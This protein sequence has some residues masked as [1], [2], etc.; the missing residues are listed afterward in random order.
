MGEGTGEMSED[1]VIYTAKKFITME[2]ALPEATAVAVKDGRIVGVGTL[3]SLKPWTDSH[4]YRVDTM[5]EDK[6]VMPGLIDPHV[7]P[8]LP[9]VLTPGVF[10]APDDWTLPMGFFPGATNHEDFVELLKGY[11]AQHEDWSV[12]FIAWGFHELW[13]GDVYREKLDALFGDRPVILWQRSF[14]ELIFNSAALDFVGLSEADVEGNDEIVW[15][16]GHFWEMGAQM[17]MVKLGPVLF[18]PGRYGAGMKTF[19]DMCHQSGVT[20]VAD[21]GTGIFGDPVGETALIRDT[22]ESNE[23]PTRI[24]LTPIIT[25]FRGRGKTPQEALDEIDEWREGNTRRVMFDRRFKIMMDGAIF[26][27]QSQFDFPGYIDGHEGAW[28]APLDV[29]REWAEAF[30]KEGYQ[31][32]A[33]VNGDLST[34]E[35]LNLL[36]H[37]QKVHPRVDHRFS[38]EHFAYATEDQNRQIKALDAV[39]SANPYYHYI[40]SDIYS[41]QWLGVDRGSQMV[42][43]GS[44]ERLGVPFTLHSDCPMAPLAPLTLAWCAANRVTI[45]G[46]VH[47]EE[48]I[49]LDAA[50]RAVTID[51]AWVL[52]YED[53]IGSIRAGKNA[54]FT[55]LE[56]DPY[57]VGAEGLKDIGIWGTVFEGELH[58]I[59]KGA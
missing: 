44:L 43:L 30:W 29:T 10:L 56:D 59:D 46:N 48:L 5:L 24:I 47:P 40:L 8:S 17:M 2:P 16:K 38:L 57:E 45:N 42:R 31:I 1:L 18:E 3:E 28:L 26:G 12:P 53:S 51:A 6:V 22:A 15:A 20:T 52:G 54:D 35:W 34:K 37:L 55:I 4:P 11:V 7:H 32:H 25:D 9:A 33:H 36:R 23:A 50:L 21:M 58:P 49:S 27:G 19:L 39:V 14:H 41:D 13:H